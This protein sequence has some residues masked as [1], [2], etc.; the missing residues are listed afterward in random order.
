MPSYLASYFRA[1]K[2]ESALFIALGLVAI[3]AAVAIWRLHPRYRAAAYPLVA[4]ALIQI[5][6]GASV[7]ART[8]RQ[9]AAL[10]EQH[11]IDAGA[12]RSDEEARMAKVMQNFQ[13]Y[14]AIEIAFVVV[15]ATLAVFMRNRSSLAAI[16][17]GCLI[18]GA[19]M[20]VFDG[21]AESRGHT[22]IEAMRRE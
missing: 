14:K 1:E 20:L 4:I 16:G 7:Y 18:Q 11:R 8:D 10:V 6:V 2:Q 21:F 17:V 9:V 3:V 12:F 5:G 15:G 13:I 19:V 22:Y